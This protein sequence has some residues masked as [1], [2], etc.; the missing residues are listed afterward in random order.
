MVS[1][2]AWLIGG[3]L[4]AGA[5]A[6]AYAF[7]DSIASRIFTLA[8]NSAFKPSGIGVD[9]AG[10]CTLTATALEG[11]FYVENSPQRSDVRED[12]QGLHTRLRFKI[13]DGATC[14]PIEGATVAIWHADALGNYSAHDDMNPNAFPFA[15]PF[16]QRR[17][18]ATASRYLR[19]HQVSDGQGLVAFDTVF[20]GWYTP[21][22]P[23]IHVK[24]I[25]GGRDVATTQLFFA[26]NIIDTIAATA[27]YGSRGASPYTNKNDFVLARTNGAPGA[28]PNTSLAGGT[29]DAD[30]TIGIVRSA[31]G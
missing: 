7:R 20:P 15:A 18:A 26:Q 3:G 2:R 24:V 22:T 23:H 19:G 5:G 1:R 12:R 30:L 13:V 27:P 29:L 25:V 11:P 31:P 21:R 9:E 10:R 14:V 8:D 16:W 28:W 17:P 4:L 6:A